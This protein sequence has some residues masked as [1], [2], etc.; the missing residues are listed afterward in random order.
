M[1]RREWD[2]DVGVCKVFQE[3]PQCLLLLVNFLFL[4]DRK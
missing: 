1:I 2:E 3:A 4:V